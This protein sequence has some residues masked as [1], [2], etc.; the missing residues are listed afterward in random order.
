MVYWVL[1]KCVI[2]LAFMC[3]QQRYV[4]VA[5]NASGVPRA[6]FFLT[7]KVGP[8]LTMGYNESIARGLLGKA[9]V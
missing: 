8:F 4:T 9:L 5:M 6:D 3:A 1:S 7:S 2:V